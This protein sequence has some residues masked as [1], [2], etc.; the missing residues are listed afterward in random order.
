MICCRYVTCVLWTD[1]YI[2]IELLQNPCRRS[3]K[4]YRKQGNNSPLKRCTSCLVVSTTSDH[5]LW[6]RCSVLGIFLG[7]GEPMEETCTSEKALAWKQQ[8]GGVPFHARP[9]RLGTY[10]RFILQSSIH[11]TLTLTT[12]FFRSTQ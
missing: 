6:A 7:H 1:P 5:G 3:T 12:G 8:R 4:D 2:F 9:E 10:K 11:G